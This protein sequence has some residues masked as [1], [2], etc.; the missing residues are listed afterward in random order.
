MF[1]TTKLDSTHNRFVRYPIV[2]VQIR[3]VAFCRG[4]ANSGIVLC[5]SKFLLHVYLRVFSP[6]FEQIGQSHHGTDVPVKESKFSFDRTQIMR[7][8]QI[9]AESH[10]FLDKFCI[11]LRQSVISAKSAFYPS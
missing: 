2:A 9:F 10:N 3:R 5:K 6:T 4:K 1:A 11:N 7:I 8:E